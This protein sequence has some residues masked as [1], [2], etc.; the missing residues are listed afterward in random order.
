[1]TFDLPFGSAFHGAMAYFTAVVLSV[2]W[3]L[4]LSGYFYPKRPAESGLW[5]LRALFLGTFAAAVGSLSGLFAT[6]SQAALFSNP[7]PW[8]D[9]RFLGLWV[10][11]TFLLL[12]LWR[13]RAKRRPGPLFVL[14]WMAAIGLLWAVVAA[15]RRLSGLT[16]Y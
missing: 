1:M 16:L 9:H 4:E 10:G 3:V 8:S 2:G 6:R 13:W 15:G 7:G 14:I 11:G 12:S 5:A